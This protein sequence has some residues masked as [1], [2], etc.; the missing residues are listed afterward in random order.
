MVKVTAVVKNLNR[1][2]EE[3]KRDAVHGVLFRGFTNNTSGGY[4]QN[5]L[6]SDPDIEHTKAAFF[7]A[8]FDNGEYMRYVSMTEDSF[9]SAK[10][11][12]GYEVSAIFLVDK[13][14]LNNYLEQ[15][16]IIQGFSNLW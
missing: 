13:E 8:F 11:R 9:R 10:V 6:V 15:S 4:N 12:R 3:L 14:S 7:T 2:K 5:P 16:G 1:A